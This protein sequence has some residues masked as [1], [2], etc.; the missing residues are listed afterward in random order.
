MIAVFA[1]MLLFQRLTAGVAA[2]SLNTGLNPV[3]ISVNVDTNSCKKRRCALPFHSKTLRLFAGGFQ[4]EDPVELDQ[5]VENPFKNP[6]LLKDQDGN[7]KVDPARLL[8]P[9]LH[10]V[11]IYFIG[12]MGRY[13]GA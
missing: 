7:L 12:M 2:F 8:S 5:G 6:N 3:K 10:G 1:L 11:N 4:W 9:R 13:V